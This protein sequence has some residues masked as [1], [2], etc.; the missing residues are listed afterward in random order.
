MCRACERQSTMMVCA[1]F[2]KTCMP[3]RVWPAAGPYL[4]KQ[5]QVNHFWGA[6]TSTQPHCALSC[7]LNQQPL[8]K[9]DPRHG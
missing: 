9:L 5:K 2:D 1:I 7:P 4:S 6:R 8:F 3:L